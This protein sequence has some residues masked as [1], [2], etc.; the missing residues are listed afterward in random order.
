MQKNWGQY[1]LGKV[2]GRGVYGEVRLGTKAD[3]S[4]FAIKRFFSKVEGLNSPDEIAIALQAS[5]PNIIKAA[6]YFHEKNKDYLVMELAD[7]NLEDHIFSS[8][9]S[10]K[11]KINLFYQ[12]VS[13]LT[14]LQDNGFYH[15]DIKP[16]NVLI[17]DGQVKLGDLG[18]SKY[19]NVKGNSCQSYASPQGLI[20]NYRASGITL[21]IDPDLEEIFFEARDSFSD[22]VWALGITFVFLLTGRVLFYDVDEAQEVADNMQTFIRNPRE[23]LSL[24]AVPEK[25][26]ALVLQMLE[27]SKRLRLSLVKDVL[28]QPEF[29][30]R[31]L[32][33]AIPGS[34]PIFYDLPLYDPGFKVSVEWMEQT[35]VDQGKN[36][37]V[38]HASIT[39][40]YY[41][42]RFI[43]SDSNVNLL[44]GACMSLM[45]S[46]Y[47][48]FLFDPE[49]LIL[50]LGNKYTK[51]QLFAQ[52]RSIMDKL[53]GRLYFTTLPKLAFSEKA[54]LESDNLLLDTPLYLSTNLHQY[55]N[56][57]LQQETIE[58][59]NHRKPV[60]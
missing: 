16:L 38:L 23:Y 6:E 29:V 28:L 26:Q 46:V 32:Y 51:E 24:N 31:G 9:L 39:C 21:N 45:S 57:L 4:V 59:R 34:A 35:L 36:S 20:P 3:G 27:P 30:K 54:V 19:K 5:H 37:F 1:K 47:S 42:A 41:M 55:M 8:F 18:L 17:K 2:L 56:S 48:A 12:L 10:N 49:E 52:E 11:E 33:R 25:W 50:L 53:A 43:D 13:A 44:M 60:W 14:Y 58:E 22:D 15:C 40:F 7:T